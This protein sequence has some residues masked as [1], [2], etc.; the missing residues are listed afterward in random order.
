MR[1]TPPSSMIESKKERAMET[2]MERRK[3]SSFIQFAIKIKIGR[4]SKKRDV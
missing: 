3:T 4:K 2:E 1:E